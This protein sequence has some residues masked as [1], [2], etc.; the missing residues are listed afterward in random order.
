MR[1]IK[2]FEGLYAVTSCG[3][4]WSYRRNKFLKPQPN[5]KGYLRVGLCIDGKT[6]SKYVHRLV[7]ESYI[8]N[9]NNYE[10]VDHI[11]ND[12]SNNCIN[13]LQWMERTDNLIKSRPEKNKIIIRCIETGEKFES[14]N[15]C[16]RKT[17]V[18]NG[19][20]SE[21]LRG[22]LGCV[23]GLHFERIGESEQ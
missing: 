7:A 12:K 19:H 16:T 11:D 2:G 17:G 1:D 10:T 8:P 23:N 9:P 18:H 15:D 5:P 3:R 4:V 20:L 21:H 6:S 14:L 13:N 22:L